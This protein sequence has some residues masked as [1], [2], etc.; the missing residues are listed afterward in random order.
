MKKATVIL[1]LMLF[2][3]AGIAQKVGTLEVLG[4]AKFKKSGIEEVVVEV[5][6]DGEPYTET[7]TA[8]DGTFELSLVGEGNYVVKAFKEGFHDRYMLFS[9]HVGEKGYRSKSYEFDLQLYKAEIEAPSSS[10]QIPVIAFDPEKRHFEYSEM[11]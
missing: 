3:T 4:T 9:T 1:G 11:L 8:F 2:A 5:F 10:F 6:K 7:Q